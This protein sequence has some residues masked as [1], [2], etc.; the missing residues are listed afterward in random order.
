MFRRSC[1]ILSDPAI[2]ASNTAPIADNSM[3]TAKGK[4]PRRVK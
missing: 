2:A 3:A 4:W 1:Q